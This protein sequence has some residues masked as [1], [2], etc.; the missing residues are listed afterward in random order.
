MEISGKKQVNI[1]ED[2][3]SAVIHLLLQQEFTLLQ[4]SER[5][6]LSHTALIKVMKELMA[7]NVVT[8]KTSDAQTTGRPPK[9]YSI[10]GDCA[11][12]CSVVITR[13][14]RYVYYFDMRGFQIN[15]H[16]S[17]NNFENMD[18]LLQ[19]VLEE[20]VHLK[21]HPRLQGR[22]LKY[23]HVGLPSGAFLGQDFAHSAEMVTERFKQTFPAV[24]IKVN[25]NI[26]YELIAEKTYG[27]LKDG[28][29]NAVLLNFDD[30]TCASFLFDGVVYNGDTRSQGL[31]PGDTFCGLNALMQ[32]HETLADDYVAG[33]EKTKTLVHQ[34]M[35]AVVAQL[36]TILRFLD[37]REVVVTGA[38]KKLGDGFLSYL[39]ESL[40]GDKI[41]RFTV[42]GKNVQAALAG[43]VWLSTYSTLQEI[44]SR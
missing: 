35:Q 9:V 17:D 40:G 28:R 3:K 11:I 12:A 4:M 37:I 20:V 10:D 38:A 23:M 7:K 13:K 36:R 42:M 29:R 27:L 22:V 8:L 19:D 44:I 15:E 32:E 43:A 30:F 24:H 18:A 14:K 41:V 1:R 26:D 16:V 2:N 6:K 5:L 21:V 34:S 25:R 33:Q 31:L 39:N